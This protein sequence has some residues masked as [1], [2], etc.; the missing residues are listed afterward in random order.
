MLKL[1][2]KNILTILHSNILLSQ[3]MTVTIIFLLTVQ[4]EASDLSTRGSAEF[5]KG[6]MGG[7]SQW[8]H[9]KQ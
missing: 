7:E 8:S 2:G 9:F 3:P 5:T 4:R 1:M 6:L